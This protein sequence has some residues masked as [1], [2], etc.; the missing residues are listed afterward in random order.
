MKV[1]E[2]LSSADRWCKGHY[3]I[4]VND[5]PVSYYHPEAVKFCLSGALEKC[6]SPLGD[7]YHAAF[8][9]LGK[10]VSTY[11][12]GKFDDLDFESFNDDL[13]TRFGDI[14]NVLEIADI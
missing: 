7:D 12:D 11:T 3:A 1:K 14:R 5:E 2:L 6:Y 9:K 13:E 4:D 10:A 8:D